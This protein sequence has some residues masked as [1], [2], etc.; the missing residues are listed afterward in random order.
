MKYV[1]RVDSYSE[2][3]FIR[4]GF[5][6]KLIWINV[7]YFLIL[8]LSL[9]LWLLLINLIDIKNWFVVRVINDKDVFVNC[10]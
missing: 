8:L 10:V 3:I 1:K 5:I 2:L 6:L 9:C 4:V 7:F